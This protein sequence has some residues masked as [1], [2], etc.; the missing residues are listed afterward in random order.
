MW[1]DSG[2]FNTYHPDPKPYYG[3]HYYGDEQKIGKKTYHTLDELLKIG[4]SNSVRKRLKGAKIGSEIKA[5]RLHANGDLMLVRITEDQKVL[6][7]EYMEVV[8]E[9]VK[10][11]KKMN[12]L[13]K[14]TTLICEKIFG[15]EEYVKK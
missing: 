11:G 2:D 3:P 9:I 13:N 10:L 7:D 15:N 5:H 1:F 6:L 14:E 8:G 12:K 4:L